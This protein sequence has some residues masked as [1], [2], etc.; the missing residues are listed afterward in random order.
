MP[1]YGLQHFRNAVFAH[2]RRKQVDVVRHQDV[3]VNRNPV[4]ADGTDEPI[5]E[6]RAILCVGKYSLAIVAP[7]DHVQRF[8]R[9]EE[10][11][12]TGH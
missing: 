6:K 8:T 7:L 11:R 2:R 3:G 5:Q 4:L 1:A 12:L 10:T 9:Y